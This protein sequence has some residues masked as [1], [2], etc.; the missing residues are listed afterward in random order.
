MR[1]ITTP[2]LILHALRD[3]DKEAL[4]S[5]LTSER[6]YATYMVP[7]LVTQQARDRMFSSLRALSERE[8]RYLFGIYEGDTFLGVIHDTAIEGSTIELGYALH[9][10]YFGR[11]IMTEAL[12]GLIDELFAQGFAEISAAAF[13]ENEASQ[14]VMQA[15][16]MRIT[17]KTESITY[18]GKTHVCVYYSIKRSN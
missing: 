15:C 1:K 12:R 16:G 18:R 11:G 8:D 4:L 10:S 7:D 3:S 14:R 9:P 2:R 6:V 5:M 17:G 13:E